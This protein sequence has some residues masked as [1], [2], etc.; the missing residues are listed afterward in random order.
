M[1]NNTH[2]ITILQGEDGFNGVK[3]Y[4]LDDAGNPT[5]IAGAVNCMLFK[6]RIEQLTEGAELMSLVEILHRH[7]D[8]PRIIRIPGF[9]K[10]HDG[11]EAERQRL[12]DGW[13]RRR[14]S[15]FDAPLPGARLFQIDADEW[16]AGHH[17]WWRSKSELR[18]AI[19]FMLCHYGLDYLTTLDCVCLLSQSAFPEGPFKAHLYFWLP[20]ALSLDDMRLWG[21]GVNQRCDHKVIDTSVYGAVHMDYISRRRCV[22]DLTEPF[23]EEFRVQTIEADPL[24]YCEDLLDSM[25]AEIEAGAAAQSS[26]EGNVSHVGDG[27]SM[28]ARAGEGGDINEWGYKAAARIIE[29]DGRERVESNLSDYAT[30]LHEVIWGNI[31]DNSGGQRGGPADATTYNIARC[32]QYFTSCFGKFGDRVDTLAKTVLEALDRGVEDVLG[33]QVLKAAAELKEANVGR[34]AAVLAEV[35]GSRLVPMPLWNDGVDKETRALERSRRVS[36][37]D[38]TAAIDGVSPD[39]DPSFF[40][41]DALLASEFFDAIVDTYDWVFDGTST[42]FID[43]LQ[44]E[45]ET[46]KGVYVI[47][48]RDIKTRVSNRANMIMDRVNPGRRPPNDTP[49]QVMNLIDEKVKHHTMFHQTVPSTLYGERKIGKV[50]HDSGDSLWVNLGMEDGH[51]NVLRIDDKGIERMSV[52][53]SL[54]DYPDAP[55]FKIGAPL[56]AGN[57]DAQFVAGV[58]N[59]LMSL[60]GFRQSSEGT[61]LKRDLFHRL[62]DIESTDHE[63]MVMVWLV[64]TI[65]QSDIKYILQITGEAG[66]GKTTA[67]DILCALIDPQTHDDPVDAAAKRR[68]SP[69]VLD[70]DKLFDALIGREAAAFDNIESLTGRHQ[71]AFC[72]VATGVGYDKRILYTETRVIHHIHVSTILTG[73]SSSE[74]RS[75]FADRLISI[76]LNSRDRNTH[77]RV[78]PNQVFNEVRSDVFMAL[79]KFAALVRHD[80]AGKPMHRHSLTETVARLYLGDNAGEKVIAGRAIN[81][82]S[83]LI[84][85]DRFASCFVAWLQH[86]EDCWGVG[87]R[88]E[89]VPM[90]ATEL[91]KAYRNWFENNGGQYRI[92]SHDGAIELSANVHRKHG[93]RKLPVPENAR[94]FGKKMAG[95]RKSITHFCFGET[96]FHDSQTPFFECKQVDNAMKYTIRTVHTEVDDFTI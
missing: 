47:D 48:S 25:K 81:E 75:D 9:Q 42:A 10:D 31:R 51:Y 83:T 96:P 29:N 20:T 58:D 35:R 56:E 62:I 84:D 72:Q 65:L 18:G 53:D 71:D 40:D 68:L 33:P 82:T 14:L 17:Q 45:M 78:R 66:A 3:S 15:F 13:V 63:V 32:T 49:V 85:T 30:K 87:G 74:T 34:Y 4:S 69:D 5:K 52:I 7:A 11:P 91:L 73:I 38:A 60:H 64:A 61:F 36:R 1:A 6:P 43:R 90:S 8:D 16:D 92:V 41:D 21:K 50:Y 93:E 37:D 39:G 79:L 70:G 27:W 59:N 22:G 57:N 89:G 46:R 19:H 80:M 77:Q 67:S 28:A 88:L 95:F 76:R 23:A 44:P 54:R 12:P 86:D 55:L 2:Q 94:S 26:G 24:C